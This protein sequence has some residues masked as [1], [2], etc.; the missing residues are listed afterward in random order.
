MK[1]LTTQKLLELA[2]LV[3]QEPKFDDNP[4]RCFKLPFLACETLS[5]E[6]PVTVKGFFGTDEEQKAQSSE[7]VLFDRIV[8]F[9]MKPDPQLNPNA[10]FL[11]PTLGGYINKILRFWLSKRPVDF[12]RYIIKKRDLVQAIF[13]HLYLTDCV[14][15][16][17]VNLCTVQTL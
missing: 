14:T 2:D 15:D 16:L 11:N 5:T 12:I 6:V 3:I 8:S 9:Y 4:E 13:N 17:L 10:K 1:Y 7:S